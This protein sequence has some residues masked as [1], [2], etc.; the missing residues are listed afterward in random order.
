[1]LS[2]SVILMYVACRV[3]VCQTVWSIHLLQATQD[4]TFT[5]APIYV[6]VQ[7]LLSLVGVHHTPI[8]TAEKMK[9]IS[10]GF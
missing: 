9:Y 10:E 4:A 6:G 1:M 8:H 7:A 2:L 5:W 3:N